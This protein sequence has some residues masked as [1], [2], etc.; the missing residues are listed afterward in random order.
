MQTLE[1]SSLSTANVAR[2]AFNLRE[3]A[4]L[5]GRSYH[6]LY[7]AACRGDLRVLAGFGRMMVSDF[8]LNRFLNSSI[9]YTPIRRK[10]AVA[11]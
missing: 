9:E 2:R 8:E 6:T 1:K 7:R 4:A 3:A 10:R 11:L 5:C